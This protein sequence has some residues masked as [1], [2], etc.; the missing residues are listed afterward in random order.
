MFLGKLVYGDGI[1]NWA[2]SNNCS[3]VFS[4]GETVGSGYAGA[5]VRIR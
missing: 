2:F 4:E 1:E 5:I 3:G